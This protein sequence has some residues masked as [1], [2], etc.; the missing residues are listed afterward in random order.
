[1]VIR[2]SVFNSTGGFDEFLR[3]SDDRDLYLRILFNDFSFGSLSEALFFWHSQSDSA[4]KSLPSINKAKELEYFLKKHG[5]KFLKFNQII[6]LTNE[7]I[8]GNYYCL[9]GEMVVGRGVYTGI[10]RRRFDFYTF[11]LLFLTF[12]GVHVYRLASLIKRRII[13]RDVLEKA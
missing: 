11:F 10:L 1:M 4:G 13:S 2:R 7:R 6:F 12:F 9:A 8:L 3:W 5:D